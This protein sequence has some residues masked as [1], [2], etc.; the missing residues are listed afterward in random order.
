MLYD[1]DTFVNTNNYNYEMLTEPV[2]DE[3]MFET[4][5]AKFVADNSIVYDCVN[6]AADP[7]F[8][9]ELQGLPVAWY[10]CENLY[11]FVAK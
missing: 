1:L 2:E 4:F 5:P 3:D 8:V 11:G 7:V 9:Y 6:H 10:D